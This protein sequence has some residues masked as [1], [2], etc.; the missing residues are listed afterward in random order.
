VGHPV[1]VD[2]VTP[3]TVHAS[4][5][6]FPELATLAEALFQWTVHGAKESTPI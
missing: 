1:S 6:I 4:L 3:D 5:L 2:P